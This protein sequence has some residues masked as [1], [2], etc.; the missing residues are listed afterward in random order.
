MPDDLYIQRKKEDGT[1]EFVLFS[2]VEDAVLS[3][4]LIKGSDLYQTSETNRQEVIKES[5][6]RKSRYK[7]AEASLL[8]LQSDD[9][10]DDDDDDDDVP[11]E[12]LNEDELFQR[13]QTRLKEEQVAVATA[14]TER[15]SELTELIKKHKISEVDGVLPLLAASND[16]EVL[17]AHLG[18]SQSQ[19]DELRGGATETYSATDLDGLTDKV[20]ERLN[21]GK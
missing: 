15:A 14:A 4:D 13:F 6:K 7:V 2:E 3:D 16:P 19:F 17:A 18:R 21:I 1:D 5:M 9:K 20:L 8:A 10:E 11:E 12:P